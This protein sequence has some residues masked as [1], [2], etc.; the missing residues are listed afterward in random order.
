MLSETQGL[1]YE[2]SDQKVRLCAIH[3]LDEF[4]LLALFKYDYL[5]FIQRG[6]DKEQ[7][8]HQE[9]HHAYQFY[10]RLD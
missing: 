10:W 5:A 2:A 6:H 4:Y 8:Y 1:N 3:P 9:G 7:Q